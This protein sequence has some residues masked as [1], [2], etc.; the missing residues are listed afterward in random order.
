[1]KRRDFLGKSAAFTAAAA[2][3][4]GGFVDLTPRDGAANL[5]ASAG[6][7]LTPP[8]QGLIPVAF[9]I[10]DGAVVIDFCGPWEV[11]QDTNKP[12]TREAL[13]ELYTVAETTKA[14]RASAGLQIIPDYTFENAPAPK[15]AVIP[16]QR[17]QTPAMLDYIRKVAK[18]TD[19]TMSVCTGRESAREHW[20]AIWKSRYHTSQRLRLV[21]NRVP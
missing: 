17:G 1:M 19:L 20:I 15:L 21:R 7:P 18:T 13:F 14:I 10:S 9:I 2:L 4:V 6:N 3:P 8:R 16:A 5:Q 12:G 11:F